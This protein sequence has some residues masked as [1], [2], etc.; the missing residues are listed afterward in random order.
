[1]S[2][3]I[4]HSLRWFS[5]MVRHGVSLGGGMFSPCSSTDEL[6]FVA[7]C[8]SETLKCLFWSIVALVR[9]FSRFKIQSSL[10]RTLKQLRNN[11]SQSNVQMP[12]TIIISYINKLLSLLFP[13]RS[14]SCHLSIYTLSSRLP[15]ETLLTFTAN[16]SGGRKR[17]EE[18]LL[19]VSSLLILPD[20]FRLKLLLSSSWSWSNMRPDSCLSIS[21]AN[22]AET[23][24][25]Q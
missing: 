3:Y 14:G 20:P 12:P 4:L 22:R 11:S 15:Y 18:V 16:D 17:S 2:Q 13:E 7:V 23:P 10:C 19:S 9:L 8:V 1:M 6:Q 25:C 21:G 24:P 5:L